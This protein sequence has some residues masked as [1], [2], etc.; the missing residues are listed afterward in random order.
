MSKIILGNSAEKLKKL[1]DDSIDLIVTDPPYRYG[2]MGKN[3]DKKQDFTEIWREC[4]RVLKPGAFAFIMNAPRSDCQLLLLSELANVGFNIEF[5][6]IFWSYAS[7]FPKAMNLSRAFDRKEGIKPILTEPLG[8]IPK[9][10]EHHN[11]ET[12]KQNPFQTGQN[13][14]KHIKKIGPISENA[15]R[16]KGSY[17][18]FQPKPAVELI[19]VVMKPLS[20]KSYIEQA[21]KNGKGLVWFENCRIPYTT[22]LE[23]INSNSKGYC[24]PS[25]SGIYGWNKP[26][27]SIK[28]LKDKLIEIS[29]EESKE[30]LKKKLV[31]GRANY[32]YSAGGENMGGFKPIKRTNHKNNEIYD[33]GFNDFEYNVNLK[34]RFPANLFVSDNVLDMGKNIRGGIN[35]STASSIFGTK[36]DQ[37]TNWVKETKGDFSRFFSL[38]LWWAEHIKKLP[39]ELQK[40]FPFLYCPKPTKAEKNKGL[41]KFPDK[42]IEEKIQQIGKT[43]A[44]Q[45]TKNTHPTGKPIKLMSY[46]ISLGSRPGD[47]ILDPF[48]GS[49]TTGIA[50]KLEDRQFILIEKDPEYYK[51]MKAR[52]KT[53][54]TQKKLF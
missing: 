13:L 51:I 3:W 4:L 18:G 25:D 52:L 32:H 31:G 49:G 29:I 30:K 47:I 34:G 44:L 1:E 35:N 2:F 26:A 50:C 9:W 16:F 6:P 53:Y 23:A 14:H 43:R 54:N 24:T 19:N 10:E 5:S 37:K 8:K 11:T 41:S 7:G 33:Y 27:K 22:E 15:K 46:L 20:E 12:T 42:Q 40:T 48:A 38:D 45:T 21:L 36:L 17:A 28:E 39:K